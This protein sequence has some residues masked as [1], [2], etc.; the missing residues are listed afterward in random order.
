[1]IDLDKLQRDWT[2]GKA[3]NPR[4]VRL[5]IDEVKRLRAQ[6]IPVSERLPEHNEWV[7]A[8]NPRVNGGRP[9]PATYYA[10]Y[11]QWDDDSYNMWLSYPPTHWQEMPPAPGEEQP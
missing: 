11:E 3:V 2:D 6:W 7:I 4:N 5:L 1:M 9:I 10:K 8:Y